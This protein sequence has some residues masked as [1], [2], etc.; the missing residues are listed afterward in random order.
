M[1]DLIEVYKKQSINQIIKLPTAK[2]NAL[3]EFIFR[4]VQH[5]WIGTCDGLPG[6]MEEPIKLPKSWFVQVVNNE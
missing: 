1:I 5:R 3:L 6:E 4:Q 2:A